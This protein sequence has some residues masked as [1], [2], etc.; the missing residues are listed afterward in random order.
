MPSVFD[1]LQSQLDIAKR[2]DGIS[3]IEIA[4]LPPNLRKVMRL[5][6][7]EVVMKYTDLCDAI[8]EL[9]AANRLAPAD[10]DAALKTLV[11]QSWLVRYGTG[12]FVSYKVNLRKRAGSRLDK[13]IWSA[14][15]SRISPAPAGGAPEEK[16]NA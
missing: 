6:M 1:R 14:L 15:D 5:M 11:E 9:P 16:K 2:E 13:D 3:P 8:Q 12:E 10:L 7:R 4:E